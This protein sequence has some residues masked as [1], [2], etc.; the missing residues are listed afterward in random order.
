MPI[1]SENARSNFKP[2]YLKPK[3]LTA[4]KTMINEVIFVRCSSGYTYSTAIK[5]RMF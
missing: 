2:T 3:E 4:R 5:L 1:Y